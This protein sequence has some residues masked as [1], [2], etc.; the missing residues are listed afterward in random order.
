[1]RSTDAITIAQIVDITFAVEQFAEVFGL[2]ALYVLDVP[3]GLKVPARLFV[4]EQV[5]IKSID[6]G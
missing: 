1:V 5:I 2:R 4:G 3:L 6:M